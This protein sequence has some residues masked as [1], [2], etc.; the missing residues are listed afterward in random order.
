[1]IRRI[2]L[3]VAAAGAVAALTPVAHANE[4]PPGTYKQWTGL[5]RPTDGQPWEVCLPHLPPI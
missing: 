2:V 1:V 3:A 4:C 5:Y